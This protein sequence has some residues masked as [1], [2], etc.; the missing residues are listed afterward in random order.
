MG[1]ENYQNSVK[2]SEE[3]EKNFYRIYSP[4]CHPKTITQCPNKLK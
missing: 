1:K 3:I 2:N 4:N